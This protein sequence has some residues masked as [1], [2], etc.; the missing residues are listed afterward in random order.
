M[1]HGI[2]THYYCNPNVVTPPRCIMGY[3]HT[4]SSQ[5]ISAL[6]MHREI[7][8]LYHGIPMHYLTRPGL[9]QAPDTNPESG[10]GMISLERDRDRTLHEPDPRYIVSDS[11]MSPLIPGEYRVR[12]GQSLETDPTR[13]SSHPEHTGQ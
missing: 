13:T 5:Y 11:V 1:H 12:V 6:A 10:S 2:P 7:S 4:V 3:E 8:T 9:N